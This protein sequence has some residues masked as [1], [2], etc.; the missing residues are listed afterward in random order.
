MCLLEADVCFRQSISDKACHKI[1]ESLFRLISTEKSLYSRASSKGA[2][3]SRLSACASVVR[4]AVDALL[5]N[6]RTKS[7]RAVLD[8]ITDVLDSPESALFELL[9]VDYTKC[10]STILHYPPHVEHLSVE[11]WENVIHFCLKTINASSGDDS[12]RGTWSPR[13]SFMDSYLGTGGD[14]STPSRMTPTLALREKPKGPAGAVEEALSCIEIL[15]GIPNAPIQENADNILL[16]LTK[17]VGSS[18]LAGSGCQRAFATVNTVVMKIVFD[19]SELTRDTLLDLV[20]AIRQHWATKLTALKDELLVTLMLAVTI[21]TDEVRKR[22]AEAPGTA[23][24]E[25]IN[26]L[27]HEYFRRSEKDILQMDEVLFDSSKHA[28]PGNF[29]LWPRLESTRAEYNWSL[30]WVIARLLEL[31]EELAPRV[32]SSPADIETPKKKQRLGSKI[33]DT[34]RD[35][36]GSSGVRRICSLQLIPFLPN[37]Y[38]GIESKISLLERLIPNIHDDNVTIASWTMIAVSR[39]RHHVPAPLNV[40]L[41]IDIVSQPAQGLM[42]QL[43]NATGNKPGT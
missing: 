43:S 36:V 35:S 16:A 6:L 25:L 5:R 15:S 19:N 20:P 32:S 12:P 11:D 42:H 27:Q 29:H 41:T 1:F 14:R 39:C 24:D 18:S 3:S 8:H 26:T 7:V 37:N 31:S 17:Y 34:F 4:T 40:C 10:L 23:I 2:A 30:V 21:L 9:S 33:D 22:P 38:T 13:S 28:S